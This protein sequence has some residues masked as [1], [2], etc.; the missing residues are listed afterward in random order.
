MIYAAFEKYLQEKRLVADREYAK[1]KVKTNWTKGTLWPTDLGSCK[2]KTILRVTGNTG[3]PNFGTRALDYMNTGVIYE[4]ETANALRHVYKERLTE[5]LELKYQM[6]SGKVDFAID[7]DT[8]NP[9]LIE[10]KVTS[11]KN[12]G[13]DANTE[14][15]KHIH[16]GQVLTYRWLYTQLYGIVPRV[17]LYYKTFGNYLECELI[18]EEE[19][20]ILKIESNGVLDVRRYG[21]NVESEIKELMLAY[22]SSELPPRLDK[23]YKGCEYRG[24]PDCQ[25]YKLCWGEG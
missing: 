6:W 19:D 4:E 12:W 25:F 22:N 5:Q 18:P 1:K 7:A 13:T 17:F 2:R 16:I 11:E 24:K 10:H 9:I 23:K 15:P 20:V 14:L 21:Y 3:D 8:D